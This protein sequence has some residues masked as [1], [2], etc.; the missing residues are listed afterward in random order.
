MTIL[1][2]FLYPRVNIVYRRE[3]AWQHYL[4]DSTRGDFKA[5]LNAYRN[6]K[7]L[8]DSI[9]NANQVKQVAVTKIEFETEKK[10]QSINFLTRQNQLQTKEIK[11]SQI[12]RNGTIAGSLVLLFLLSVLYY[13][14]RQKNKK[15][16]LL[17]RQKEVIDEKK[18]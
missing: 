6:Y 4:M 15:N 17:Q 1:K 8:S 11:Q 16:R 7:K 12:I 14:N 18:Q 10:E 9:F 3:I 5:A 2:S 13:Q